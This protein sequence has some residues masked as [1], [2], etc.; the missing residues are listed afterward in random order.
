MIQGLKGKL[1]LGLTKKK[2]NLGYLDNCRNGWRNLIFSN[3]GY[4]LM[5]KLII[6]SSNLN[7]D[8]RIMKQYF[9]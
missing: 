3:L 5:W 2:L 1:L 9:G 7:F 8:V 6:L 4:L